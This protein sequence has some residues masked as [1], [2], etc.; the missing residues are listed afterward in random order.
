LCQAAAKRATGVLK[1]KEKGIE[2]FRSVG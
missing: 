1:Q 2:D